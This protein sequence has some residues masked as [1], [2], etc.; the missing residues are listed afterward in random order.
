MTLALRADGKLRELNERGVL[1]ASD[2]HVATRLSTLAAETDEKCVLALALA[3][4]SVRHGSVVLDLGDV[5][6]LIRAEDG[7]PLTWPDLAGW[8]AALDGSALIGGPLH[9]EG[10]LLW[11][12]GYWRQE[13]FVAEQLRQ[14]AAVKPVLDQ[15]RLRSALARLWPGPEPDDQRAA[16]QVCASS[17]VAVLAGGPG[18]GKTTTVARMLVAL[19]EAAPADPPLRIALAAPTGKA[20][21]R[22]R[23][24]MMRADDR[25]SD[26]ERTALAALPSSTLHRLLGVRRGSDRF[27]HDASNRLPYDVLVVDE[28]SM[29]SLSMF[30]KLLEALRRDARLVLVGDPDQLVSVEAGAV[31]ADIVDEP[32]ALRDGIAVLTKTHRFAGNGTIDLL[33]KAIRRGDE[34]EVIERL[35]AGEPELEFVE[36]DDDDA[37]PI[38][39]LRPV[40]VE[41]A[42][43]VAKAAEAGDALEAL[44]ALDKHRLLCAHREGPRGV[45]HWEQQVQSWLLRDGLVSPRRDGR[46]AGQP[47]LVTSNDYD[48][49]LWNGDTGVVVQEGD[50]LVAYFSTGG[51]PTRVPLGRLGPVVP[52]QAMTVHRSQGSQFAAVTVLLPSATS[53]LQ[54]RETLY[55]AVTR[56]ENS[57]RVV[58]SVQAV[59][60]AVATRVH[61][62][63]G[64]QARLA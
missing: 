35:Q 12:D 19:K 16:A 52:M 57:V 33:A 62:A 36:L 60:A 15:D 10:D 22:L 48:N 56:A 44:Q 23:E 14:R 51:L 7:K 27:W 46:Y 34:N 38:D 21:A 24:S 39:V 6:K 45:R 55:T 25:L 32:G 13:V 40:L 47:L 20:A 28:A 31:L 50:E 42:T 63:S 64:L 26:A 17:S 5:E 54:T 18:T 59:R 61:R 43:A 29:V 53:P 30:A 4:R 49:K 9:R 3:V 8:R 11:L 1:D 37:V 2:V 41:V 58:G